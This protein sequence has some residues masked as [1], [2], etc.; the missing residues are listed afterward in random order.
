MK[1]L[2]DLSQRLAD[3]VGVPSLAAMTGVQRSLIGRMP[4]EPSG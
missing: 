2:A 3:L 4:N 1:P